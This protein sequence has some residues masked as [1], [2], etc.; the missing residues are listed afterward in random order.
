M[1]TVGVVRERNNQESRVSLVPAS[2]GDIIKTGASVVVEKNA[3]LRAGYGDSE[4]EK[5]GAT[6]LENRADVFKA[7]DV[8]LAVD[9]SD[10]TPEDEVAGKLL[11]ALFDPYFNRSLLDSLQKRKA[12]IVALELIPR[13]S[14]AQSMDVLS[15]QANLA[16]Y[17]AVISAAQRLN[18]VMPLF[19]TAAGTIKPARVLIVGAGVAGLQAIATAKRLGAV[20]FAYDVRSAVKEQ[21]GSLGAKFVEINLD[22]SGEGEGGYAKSLSEASLLKQRSMLTDFA[23]DCD[24]I[25]TTAQIPGKTAPRLLD[26][27]LLSQVKPGSVIVDMAAK[28]G[29]NIEGSIVDQW[30]QIDNAWLYGADNL[31]RHVAKDASFAM[32]KNI[33]SLLNLFLSQG[34]SLK[35]EII[36]HST[37]C[38][39][40]RWT[41]QAFGAIEKD[42]Q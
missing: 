14:R 3:G 33:C 6:I 16:G 18:K 41:H 20:V 23:K 24:I 5:F 30:L 37:I 25:I 35:D 36:M 26:T 10:F 9:G 4:Y 32:S 11:L 28:T 39:E 27:R 2:V 19:M 8:I 12:S 17:V 42:E 15:S 7:A 21:V 13:I 40:G 34:F 1:K 22:E 29:G 38:H 31:A